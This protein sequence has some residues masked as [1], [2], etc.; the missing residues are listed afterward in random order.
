MHME[1]ESWS[2]VLGEVRDDSG[3]GNHGTV[4]Q[5]ANPSAVDEGRFGRAAA[6]TGGWITVPDSASL[7]PDEALTIS[8]WVRPS[9]LAL[10]QSGGIVVKRESYLDGTAYAMFL[11]WEGSSPETRLFLDIAEPDNR[12][13]TNTGF[14]IDQWYHV[15]AVF[16]GSL[17]VAERSR[18]YVDGVVDAVGSEYNQTIGAYPSVLEIGRLRGG[19]GSF[20]GLIDEVA[21][22]TRALTDT[23]VLSLYEATEALSPVSGPP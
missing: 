7:N 8:A 9:Y 1:E 23:E 4:V 5:S 20:M 22:W 11:W 18:V 6:L 2:G 17:P 19:G 3:E 13:F 14:A 15:A 16:D 21:I 10:G 12:F